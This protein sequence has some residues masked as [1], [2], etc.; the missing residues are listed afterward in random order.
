[1]VSPPIFVPGGVS[2]RICRALVQSGFTRNSERCPAGMLYSSAYSC[3]Y[4]RTHLL[5]QVRRAESF[6]RIKTQG[7]IDVPVAI[8]LGSLEEHCQR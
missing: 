7:G 2:D 8:S 5:L 6:S 3:E 1:M 4:L